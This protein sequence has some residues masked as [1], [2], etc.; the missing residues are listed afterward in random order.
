MNT[1]KLLK[2][3]CISISLLG[4]TNVYSQGMWASVGSGV[5]ASAL[6][7]AEY[8]GDLYIGKLNFT[9]P[10]ELEK[11]DGT[12]LTKPTGA[13]TGPVASL[14]VHDYKL[15]VGGGYTQIGGKPANNVATWDGTKWISLGSELD[16]F[17]INALA[18]YKDDLYAAGYNVDPS[19]TNPATF[20]IAKWDGAHWVG[21]GGDLKGG[22]GAAVF[23]L[24]VYN[25]ELYACGNFTSAGGIATPGIARWNGTNWSA[26]G[27]TETVGDVIYIA[28]EYQGEL[29]VGGAFTKIGGLTANCIAK[30]D[31]TKWSKVS[32]GPGIDNTV[33][34]LT[35]YNNELYIGGAFS[36]ADEVAAN[37]IVKW[38]GSNW[39]SMGDGIGKANDPNEQIWAITPYNGEIYVSGTL[40]KMG[41]TT[42]KNV[43]RWNPV[44]NDVKDFLPTSNN[45][46]IYPN[47]FTQQGGTIEV[48]LANKSAILIDLYDLAGHNLSTLYNGIKEVGTHHFPLAEIQKLITGVYLVKVSM[49]NT[50]YTEKLIIH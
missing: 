3:L 40:T 31:G 16:N 28:R 35:E 15:Y 12:K 19:F 29:Y 43:A 48:T 44:T 8:K 46:K 37:H 30:W 32:E 36:K 22:T 50:I 45:L 18:F 47:P 10:D 4:F 26:V 17:C 42:I 34:T 7:M 13:P 1:H 5:N 25:D 38:N 9:S 33:V 11:W 23:S 39:I 21:V 49:N 41:T 2:Y 14:I 27:S 24:S 20:T 6:T